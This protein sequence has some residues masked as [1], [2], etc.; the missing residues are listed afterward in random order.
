MGGLVGTLGCI[1]VSYGQVA[2]DSL[3]L[4]TSSTVAFWGCN[5]FQTRTYSIC[6]DTF[7]AFT[8]FCLWLLSKTHNGSLQGAN[9]F[10]EGHLWLARET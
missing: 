5:K 4:A 1:S 10:A 3:I 2:L 6:L 7:S 9:L 8:P